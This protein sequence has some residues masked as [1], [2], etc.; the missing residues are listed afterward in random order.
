VTAGAR[1]EQ[2]TPDKFHEGRLDAVRIWRRALASGEVTTRHNAESSPA[3]FAAAGA[4]EALGLVEF[5]L[6]AAEAEGL[7]FEVV[8]P[9]VF[10]LAG[11]ES[12]GL[13]FTAA[14][15]TDLDFSL[16][17]AQTEGLPFAVIEPV[18]FILA[19]CEAEGLEFDVYNK[20]VVDFGLAASQSEALT[21]Q[22]HQIAETSGRVSIRAVG[23]T[24]EIRHV[25]L[26]HRRKGVPYTF[27]LEAVWVGDN[28]DALLWASEDWLTVSVDGDGAQAVGTTRETAAELGAGEAGDRKTLDLTLT[29]PA[30][31]EI[32]SRVIRLTV[33]LGT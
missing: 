26:H 30:D 14:Q 32:R 10:V 21:F 11:C 2:G 22:P 27:Q 33:G 28:D 24:Y 1:M 29:I 15:G 16:A 5:D 13:D 25:D 18:V 31:E 12:V 9:V 3:T 7:D 23:A 6:A 20:L 4:E 8:E 17:A 19:E